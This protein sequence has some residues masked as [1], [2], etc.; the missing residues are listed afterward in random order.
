MAI[1]YLSG[2]EVNNML[3][4]FTKSIL[5]FVT[6]LFFITGNALAKDIRIGVLD[7]RGPDDAIEYWEQVAEHLNANIT[8]QH[9]V[10]V[11]HSYKSL[12]KAVADG[13]LEF[14]VVNPAQYI[15]LEVKYGAS[16]IATQVSH[17]G[18]NEL[19]YFGTVIF[20]KANRTDIAK[21]SD[22]RGK[23]LI[24]AS[25]TAFASWL[26]TRDELKRQGISSGDLASVQFAGS[27]AD[28]V[29]MAVKNGEV[30]AGSV[31]T[32]VL[33][34]MVR[35]GKITLADF[36]ILNQ[37]NVE[38]FP[39][40]LSSELY[41]EFVFARLRHTDKLLAN[42]VAALLLLMP[43]GSA[44]GRYTN[45]IGWTVPENYEKVRKLLQEWRLPPYENYGKVT[46]REAVR[47]HWATI[48]LAFTSFMALLLIV[49]LSLSIKQRRK[50][51]DILKEA[52]QKLDLVNTMIEATPDAV[53]IKD[54]QGRYV[55]VNPQATRVFGKPAEYIIGKTPSDL[56]P[57][58]VAQAMEDSD[59]TVMSRAIAITYEKLYAAS[60]PPIQ[61]LVTKG[62][63]YDSKGEVDAIFA[64]ARD[65]TDLKCLQEEIS[66][67]VVQ[68]ET[69]LSK[70]RQ[71]EGI[72]PICSY[73]KK[74]RDNKESWQ[75]MEYYI[76]EHS[77]A[78]FSHGICPE[79]YK[80]VSL[81]IDA[82]KE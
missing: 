28:K 51:Y 37:K 41:P 14:M 65:I 8:D 54:T 20:T 63:M 30:D 47:Q 68:L 26:V 73:C 36:R 67:K 33:E 31:R 40:L 15:E 81:E 60:G 82:M 21:L 32:D 45:P 23:S 3:R 1:P 35:E 18:Q 70:V 22:L 16:P 43:H 71:L 11:P 80:T 69:A 56:F 13:Q 57:L 48:I 66:D 10:I 59:S 50:K 24:T 72:I 46:L 2:V 34:Q 5:L 17:A 29:V 53:F 74:I 64:V 49:Y 62:P 78:K 44:T 4:F 9:F 39:F 25:K 77:E 76:S 42:H 38:G 7:I 12:E 6:T 75:Q 52:K 55:F 79:C 19:S 58:D 27:S 61:M